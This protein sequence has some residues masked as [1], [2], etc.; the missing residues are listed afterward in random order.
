MEG[1][2]GSRGIAGFLTEI[3]IDI[4]RGRRR[5]LEERTSP[6]LPLDASAR[7]K[8]KMVR[9]RREARG[10]L[11][12][13]YPSD[14]R[15]LPTSLGNVLRAA[16]DLAG[17]RYG[18]PTITVWPRL[19][20]LLSI[21]VRSIVDDQRNQLDVT[22]RFSL[23]FIIATIG[24][25][26]LYIAILISASRTDLPF[27]IMLN[28]PLIANS[29][30]GG[31]EIWISLAIKYWAWTLIPVSTSILAFLFYRGAIN[32]AFTYGTAL[33]TA[34]D[35]QRFELLKALHLPLP[36][37][38]VHEKITNENLANF[39]TEEFLKGENSKNLLI[40]TEMKMTGS[41][42]QNK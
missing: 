25:L 12:G 3:G 31:L 35:L 5:L 28:N 11:N 13:F 19:Y 39:F 38:S 41:I 40:H 8:E 14:S 36:T 33:K 15:L 6:R 29:P 26:T 37:D 9:R 34:F 21:G 42:K 24:S 32:I 10:R 18:L 27:Y 16:E 7:Q 2:W 23:M 20:P 22:I 1:Y 30:L 17:Y 4:Q